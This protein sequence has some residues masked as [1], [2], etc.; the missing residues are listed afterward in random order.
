MNSKVD[1]SFRDPAG[2]LYRRDGILLRQVNDPYATHYEACVASG[3]YDR[4]ITGNLLIPHTEIDDAGMAP[5]KYRV[6]K[7]EEIPYVSY[8]YEWSFTQLKD[9]ALL[10]LE[11]Q[12]IAL[13]YGL[14]LKDAS[15]YNVQFRAGSAIFIDSL[16]FERY[17]EGTPWVAYRQ[18]CQ[19]FLA[20]L[21]LMAVGD[22][23]LR[24]LS[25]RYLDGLPLDL[26]SSMLPQSSWLR[27]STFA[28]IHMHARSQRKHQDDAR[29]HETVAVSRL[30]KTMLVALIASLRSAVE[31]LAAK[32]VPTEWGEYYE[33]TNYSTEAM[34]HKESLLD[35]LAETYLGRVA[36]VHD[37]GANTGRFSR[38]VAARAKQVIA[39]DIDEMAVERHCRY[40]KSKG[41]TNVLPLVMDLG[42]P[43]PAMGW[44]LTERSSFHERAKG[45]AAVAL[46]LVHHLCITNN[47][48]LDR[49][50]QFFSGVFETL[51]I[52]FV[53][54][55]D[56]Q[57]QRM[58]ATRR[59][60]FDN[61]NV[62]SFE[63]E[64]SRHFEIREQ[65][66]VNESRR[67]LYAMTRRDISV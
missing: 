65:C 28:H 6:L 2:F 47:V 61:Y 18:F 38:I 19:H 29:I 26:V 3:L 62:A 56:S 8:P 7:P 52:E 54:K 10:T 37:L 59:D 15:A 39:H 60:V 58:L 55:E 17:V 12:R 23:R 21:T 40:I 64:F 44:D 42:N 66:R 36:V 22:L 31:K 57:V 35:R 48:P 1:A 45:T 27:Y 16:S 4:L 30:S 9:A 20:P 46:A 14:S 43:A 25:F 33:D 5:G 41:S 32:D 13:E 11:I 63:R 34:R 24:Q 67:S 53:P 51:I 49:L 50:A